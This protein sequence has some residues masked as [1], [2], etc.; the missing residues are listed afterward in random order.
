MLITSDRQRRRARGTATAKV[1]SVVAVAGYH[2]GAV[3]ALAASLA[4][5]LAPAL[6]TAVVE[7]ANERD[8]S[9]EAPDQ[10]DATTPSGA[11]AAING[12]R[13]VMGNEAL[14][15]ELGVSLESLGDGA[16]RLRRRGEHVMFVSIDGHIA[17]FVGVAY[18]RD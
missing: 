7:A 1:A 9:V 18:A 3:V 4:P 17:G 12:R 13:V 15:H 8:L 2:D 16:E 5:C 6:A 11:L 10:L 14:F